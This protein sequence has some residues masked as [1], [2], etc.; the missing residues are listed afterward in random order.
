MGTGFVENLDKATTVA[1]DVMWH[2]ME[3]TIASRA[4]HG[5]E[6]RGLQR[7]PDGET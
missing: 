7:L 5:D 1:E 2:P 6:R 4:R 3:A